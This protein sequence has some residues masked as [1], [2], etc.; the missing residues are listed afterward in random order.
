GGSLNYSYDDLGNIRQV[1]ATG[2]NIYGSTPIVETNYSYDQN[3]RLLLQETVNGNSLEQVRFRY[4]NEGNQT[5]KAEVS[6]QNGNL[7]ASNTL[8]FSYNG[9]NQLANVTD[10]DNNLTVYIYNAQGLRTSKH[11]AN[12][13]TS[14]KFYYDGSA[15]IILETTAENAVTAKNIRGIHL[16][17]RENTGAEPFYY[18]YNAHG[19]VTKLVDELGNVIKDYNY[20]PFGNEKSSELN[21]LGGNLTISLWQTEAAAIDNPFRYCGE[22]LDS[23]TN[24]YYL[25]ARYYDTS[26]GRFLS[27]DPVGAGLNWYIYSNN[28]P[29][30]FIDTMGLDAILINKPV[31]SSANNIGIEHMGGFFQDGKDDWWFF[32]WGTDVKYIKIK[33]ESIFDSMDK[34]NEWL[35]DYRDPN[36]PDLRLLNPDNPYHDSVYIKGD[37]IE[38]HKA[39]QKFHEEYKIAIEKG[40]KGFLVDNKKYGL[41][42]N[43]CGQVT[44]ELIMKG[45]LSSGMN[46]GDY[47]SSQWYGVAV[48][49]NWNV[50]NIQ[51]IFYN[52]ATNLEG[53]EAA[54]QK[55]RNKYE[56]KS[57]FIQWWYSG[58]KKN[59]NTIS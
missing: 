23:E 5:E 31:D 10:S 28:N 35:I 56:G 19:D 34:M 38:S 54:I 41:I 44:M 45:T 42:T 53:F 20:D 21:P 12:D 49:P 30:T 13:G 48:I 11:N 26:T 52:S 1:V 55:Q 58:L 27:E 29:I 47:I 16:I 33:D 57:D 40:E 39:A 18:L 22:C 50:I 2:Q 9:F 6:K 25:R 43:N 8:T 36:D 4:D 24:N 7:I 17:S 14:T 59:I 3:N 46:V 37:F 15:N 51:S 32:Y